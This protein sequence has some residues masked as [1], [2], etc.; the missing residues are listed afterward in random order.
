MA[1]CVLVALLVKAPSLLVPM[2]QDQGL[3]HTVAQEILGGG[4]A[5]R[6]AWD[7]KPPGVFYV[8]A[9]L[10]AV[11]SD[12][13]RVCQI[14]AL[15]PRCGSLLFWVTDF[16]YAIF[17]A[18]LVMRL[19]RRLGFA[20]PAAVL[21]F[22]FTAVFV[23]LTVLDAEGSTPEKYALAPAVGVLLVAGRRRRSLLAAGALAGVAALF[24]P[25]DLASFGALS[26]SLATARRYRDLGLAWAAL[27][28]V[29]LAAF[30]MLALQG[31]GAQA[32]DATL[33]YNSARAGFN[34][35]RIPLAAAST[36]WQLFRD[37]LALLWLPAVVGFVVA[38]HVKAW[39]IVAI[40]AALDVLALFAGGD[41][42]TREYYIQLVPSG[43]LL[44]G[45]G[46][47]GLW[48]RA[49]HDSLHRLW[50]VLSCAAIALLISGFQTGFAVRIWNEYVAHGWTTT[51][52]EHLAALVGALP[53]DAR[54]FVWGDEAQLYALADRLPTTRFLN[55]AGLAM[56][57]DPRADAR[58]REVFA[59][60]ATDPPAV[61]VVDRRSSDDDP[62]G[63]LGLNV[64]Y[65]PELSALL[66][67][68]YREL[69]AS[70][71]AGYLGSDREQ[72]FVRDDVHLNV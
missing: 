54:L 10:L 13:W 60:L 1:L 28:V 35:G 6:D 11:L 56:T 57:G 30:G 26:I 65:V 31:A 36:T 64:R 32:L 67:Q 51:S 37:G 9:A 53:P 71:L 2:G 48:S 72:V 49:R 43:A 55:T 44:A 3:Y 8:H 70:V 50:I 38:W 25:T 29:L 34:V 18:W 41:K 16:L 4:V 62:D 5:Y 21:A 45:L 42:F 15:Q 27:A 7:P 17:L 69:D 33:G 58:R 68:R 23:N 12:P 59:R 46:L 24:K 61:I 52:S 20:L 22:G 40:W 47:H 39:R 14:G 63:R 66:A 19:A